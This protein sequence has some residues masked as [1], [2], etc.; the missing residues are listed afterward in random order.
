MPNE[1]LSVWVVSLCVL[2]QIDRYGADNYL[3]EVNEYNFESP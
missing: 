1:T 2:T 3:T